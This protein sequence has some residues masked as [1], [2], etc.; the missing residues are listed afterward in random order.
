[1]D[2]Q[3]FAGLRHDLRSMFT[4]IMLEADALAGSGVDA[5]TRT[6]RAERIA[7]AVERCAAMLDAARERDRAPVSSG[8][9]TKVA[10]VLDAVG[11][12]LAPWIPTCVDVRIM[13]PPRLEARICPALTYRILLNLTQN[14]ASAIAAAGQGRTIALSAEAHGRA[15]LVAVADDGPGLP[16]PVRD[17]LVALLGRPQRSRHIAWS[18]RA[19]ASRREVDSCS[20]SQVLPP[21]VDERLRRGGEHGCEDIILERLAYYARQGVHCVQGVPR[22]KSVPRITDPALTR[23][24]PTAR[25]LRRPPGEHG[26]GLPTAARLARALGGRLQL[27]DHPPRTTVFQLA[28]PGCV[29]Q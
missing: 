29:V 23:I 17:R 14:A 26:L 13:C 3:S 16:L 1:M 28:V 6:R 4:L 27:V 11:T 12:V 25:S 9:T 2:D 20:G 10:D 18:G 19:S 22:T 15:L 21:S 7:N 5:E 8:A 24:P